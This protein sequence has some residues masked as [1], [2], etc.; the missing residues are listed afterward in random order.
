MIEFAINNSDIVT[1]VSKSLK[2][3]TLE[4]FKIK[5]EIKIIP[6]FID[7]ALYCPNENDKTKKLSRTYQIFRKSK[8]S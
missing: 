6:N 7:S 3:D 5:K 1:S 2:E 8:K 4:N